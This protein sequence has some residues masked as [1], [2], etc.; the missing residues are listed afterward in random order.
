MMLEAAATGRDVAINALAQSG[1]EVAF[2]RLDRLS[3]EAPALFERMRR[4][5]PMVVLVDAP[6]VLSL[7]VM[8]LRWIF[9]GGVTPLVLCPSN[10]LECA[11]LAQTAAGAARLLHGPVFLLLEE[12][13]A[14]SVP[15]DEQPDAIEL[16]SPEQPVI[17]ATDLPA[18]EAELRQLEARHSK[19]LRGI[20]ATRDYR[21]GPEAGKPEWLV[22]TYGAA[23]KPASDAVAQAVQQGQRVN[24][25]GIRML[26]PLPEEEILKAVMGI[27]H[28]VVAERNLGQYAQEIR[29]LVPELPVI[30]AGSLTIP[31]SSDAILARL[32]RSPRCC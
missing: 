25:L 8:A 19:P 13:V 11:E 21:Q 17:D 4:G 3:R 1:V 18:P 32:Q 16:E 20:R 14:N 30:P 26:W 24:L 27:K 15:E 23:S 7:D 12:S 9:P 6:D 2:V 29:R 10:A 22:I 5:D 31:V 28:I